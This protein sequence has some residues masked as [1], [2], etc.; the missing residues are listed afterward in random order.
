MGNIIKFDCLTGLKP[1]EVIE[2]VMLINDEEALAKYYKPESNAI[3]HFKFPEI[4]F[5]ITKKA[6][7]SLVNNATMDIATSVESA[8]DLSYNAIRFAARKRK[9]KC[10]ILYCRKIHA[11]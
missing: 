2:S 3:E 8:C 11:S 1:A 10:D 9:I 7:I 4:F 5:R 6:Y